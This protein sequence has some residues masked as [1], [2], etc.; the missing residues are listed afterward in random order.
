M[1][2]CGK[3]SWGHIVSRFLPGYTEW[4]VHGE[5][6][7]S[8][9][10]SQSTNG[11][12]DETFFGQEDIRGLVRDALG[13]NSLPSDNTQLE[14]TTTKGDTEES[15]KNG[16]HGDECVSYKRLLEEC[17]K[18][19]YIGC[20]T[21]EG[22]IPHLMVLPSSAYEAK[23][24]TKDL[25]LVINVKGLSHTL[26][27]DVLGL[28][29][30]KA[31]LQ[32][33][34]TKLVSWNED[35]DSPCKWEGIRCNPRSNRV[36]DLVLDVF[37]L[38]GKMGRGL[39]QL[40]FLNKLSLANNN[41][42][43][44]IGVNFGQ[45][46][47]LRVIDLSENSLSESVPSG[48]FDQCG[49]L[50]SISLAGD[51]F[52]GQVPDSL[53]KCSS[54]GTFNV[55]GNQFSRVLPLGVWS[56][57]GLRVLDVSD[58]LL[59]AKIGACALLRSIDFSENSFSGSLPSTLQKL[60]L[61]KELNFHGNLLTCEELD[62]DERSKKISMEFLSRLIDDLYHSLLRR[63]EAAV[64]SGGKEQQSPQ[65]A[66]SNAWI[67]EGENLNTGALGIG[68]TL[69]EETFIPTRQVQEGPSPAFV[70]ENIDLLRT[71]I[72]E[73]NNRGQE[74]VTHH[75]L[76]N[77][78]SGGAGSENSRMSPSTEKV[79]G[80][81]SNGSSRSRSRGRSRS[82]RKH[83]KRISKKKGISKSH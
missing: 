11:N 41:L 26:D 6:T 69:G 29:V 28:I 46:T 65:E 54:F 53:G 30:F 55:L 57:N 50:R 62:E 42:T 40:K 67:R 81:S 39:M 32:D 83:R 5:H 79:G 4:T 31:D 59:E 35:D 56:L 16:D 24:F 74:N 52:T 20:K 27:D 12:V 78:G 48:F 18:E 21:S 45:L 75:R 33:P 14:D 25:G 7:I 13:I 47:D 80:Y 77:E 9:P 10:P 8:L 73:L 36:S 44:G 17:D 3:R 72:K 51:K 68:R 82:A 76:F 38:S 60:S 15:T 63:Q 23:K 37:G 1:V 58:N 19:L 2:R 64:F 43:G 61:C 71:I 70:K 66:K 22:C 34:N 49:S